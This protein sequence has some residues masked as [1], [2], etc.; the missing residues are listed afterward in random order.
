MRRVWRGTRGRSRRR[1]R[2]KKILW[3]PGFSPANF[4]HVGV[5]SKWCLSREQSE[6]GVLRLRGA[7]SSV[8]VS[9]RNVE[10][11]RYA[12][13]GHTNLVSGYGTAQ[14]IGGARVPASGGRQV[15]GKR[16]NGRAIFSES[17][18]EA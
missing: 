3:A 9:R 5:P 10:F 17:R 13:C 2:S 14:G 16:P 8:E 4:P 12:H 6:R 11:Y 1:L 18:V 15:H 7:V